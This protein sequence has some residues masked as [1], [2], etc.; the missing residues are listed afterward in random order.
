MAPTVSI[1]V[2]YWHAKHGGI[3]CSVYS[4]LSYMW[5]PDQFISK[6]LKKLGHIYSPAFSLRCWV[7][8]FTAQTIRVLFRTF[9]TKKGWIGRKSAL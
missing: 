2:W 5:F 6:R 3:G 7:L 1:E 4:K 8:R 9:E